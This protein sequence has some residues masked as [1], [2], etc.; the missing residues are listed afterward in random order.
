MPLD[1]SRDFPE[2]EYKSCISNL[3]AILNA[4]SKY[5]WNVG[6]ALK[7]YWMFL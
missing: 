7:C 6:N 2:K 1:I 5:F 4:Y 3:L